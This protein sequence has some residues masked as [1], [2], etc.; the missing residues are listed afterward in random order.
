ME[1]GEGEEIDLADGIGAILY[2]LHTVQA[3]RKSRQ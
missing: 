3:Y 1:R 2:S